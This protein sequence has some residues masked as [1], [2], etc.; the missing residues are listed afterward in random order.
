MNTRRPE[1]YIFIMQ[2]IMSFFSVSVCLDARLDIMPGDFYNILCDKFPSK[3]R[4][5][6]PK[7]VNNGELVL[8]T[9]KRNNQ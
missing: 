8:D 7:N 6:S 4:T 5:E 3:V 2:N 9:E 1:C